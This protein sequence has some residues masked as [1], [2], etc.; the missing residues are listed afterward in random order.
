MTAPSSVMTD[1][2]GWAEAK[3]WNLRCLLCSEGQGEMIARS[4]LDLSRMHDHLAQAHGVL[5]D[6]FFHCTHEQDADNR[7][8]W[9]LPDGRHWLEVEANVTS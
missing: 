8:L 4:H 6:A 5:F 9:R 1:V 2:T 7:T 3:E